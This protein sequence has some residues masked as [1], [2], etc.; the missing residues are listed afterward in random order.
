MAT[1]ACSVAPRRLGEIQKYLGLSRLLRNFLLLSQQHTPRAR[2]PG[3][4]PWAAL[5]PC[6]Q[7]Q[8]CI[9]PV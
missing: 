4:Q 2:E 8:G 5:A 3:Y 9:Q 7:L 6:P 1:R